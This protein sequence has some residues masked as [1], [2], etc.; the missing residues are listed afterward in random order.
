[1]RCAI[2]E[3]FKSNH[4]VGDNSDLWAELWRLIAA[5]HLEI[6]ITFAKAHGIETPN[7]IEQFD[8]SHLDL[9]GDAIADKLAE[10]TA[11]LRGTRPRSC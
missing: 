6:L 1:M 10:R 8:I 11:A 9:V 4:M 7:F 3:S 2:F 5:K